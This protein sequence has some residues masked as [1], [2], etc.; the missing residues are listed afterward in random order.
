M[1]SYKILA[2]IIFLFITFN[3]AQAQTNSSSSVAPSDAVTGYTY[4]FDAAK[5]III[6][7]QIQPNETNVIAKPI[8]KQKSFPKIGNNKIAD[9]AYHESLK[10]WMEKNPTIIIEA[11]KSRKDIVIPFIK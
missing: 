9:S 10:V 1:R 3:K 7:H 4:D 8:I 6:E 2:F 5:K 11:L